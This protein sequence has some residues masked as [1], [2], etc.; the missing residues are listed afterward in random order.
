MWID[1]LFSSTDTYGVARLIL[2]LI[3]YRMH[4]YF[5]LR[6]TSINFLIPLIIVW[7]DTLISS[8]DT[9]GVARLILEQNFIRSSNR[10]LSSSSRVTG[11]EYTNLFLQCHA[12]LYLHGDAINAQEALPTLCSALS[13]LVATNAFTRT[14]LIQVCVVTGK[15]VCYHVVK[16]NSLCILQGNVFILVNQY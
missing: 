13:T 5:L 1:T 3:L 4:N 9:D 7:I 15:F 6:I 10:D 14:S 11:E 16:Y 8:N 2:E 12:Q